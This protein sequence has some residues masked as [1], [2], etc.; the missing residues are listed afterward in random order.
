[1]PGPGTPSGGHT[2]PLNTT[3]FVIYDGS[4]DGPFWTVGPN[5]PDREHCLK[6]SN[7]LHTGQYD[8][9]ATTLHKHTVPATK[10]TGNNEG[11]THTVTGSTKDHKHNINIS[12]T[13][14][15]EHSVSASESGQG[16]AHS[17]SAADVDVV[18]SSYASYVWKRIA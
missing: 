12:S 7:Q 16:H 14:S 6:Y 11:H 15:H 10:E 3:N 18:Q 17:F 9:E 2:H 4:S 1:L 5:S 13:G 8:N